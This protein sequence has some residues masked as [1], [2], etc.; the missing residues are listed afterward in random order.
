LASY[1]LC[2]SQ[3]SYFLLLKK[4]VLQHF[5][6]A[7]QGVDQVVLLVDRIGLIGVVCFQLIEFPSKIL[8]ILPCFSDTFIESFRA[9]IKLLNVVVTF[10]DLIVQL[11]T[12]H[13]R[14]VFSPRLFGNLLLQVI[15]PLLQSSSL[16]Y[17]FGVDLNNLMLTSE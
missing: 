5:T 9:Q 8:A 10:L 13:I 3:T 7:I 6:S 17:E 15:L 12:I 11:F 2:L 16:Q 1:Q 14:L 4:L